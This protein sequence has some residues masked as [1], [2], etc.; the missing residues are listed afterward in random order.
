MPFFPVQEPSIGL[1]KRENDAELCCNQC[2]QW[3]DAGA[4]SDDKA[5]FKDIMGLAKTRLCI[6]P[7]EPHMSD[8]CDRQVGVSTLMPVRSGKSSMHLVR[9]AQQHT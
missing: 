7:A 9:E 1:L 3:L 5:S 8:I 4:G 6:D 2:K